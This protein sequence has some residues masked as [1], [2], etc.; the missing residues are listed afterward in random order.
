MGDRRRLDRKGGERGEKK[1]RLR[2]VALI[3]AGFNTGQV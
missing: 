2:Q 1:G 3:K